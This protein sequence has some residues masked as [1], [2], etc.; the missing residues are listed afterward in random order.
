MSDFPRAEVE[1]TL[2]RCFE[3]RRR[4]DGSPYQVPGITVLLYAGEGRFSREE[5]LLNMVH[6]N[7]VIRESGWRPGPGFRP[8]PA[9]P[10]R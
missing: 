4:A 6:V 7:E 9:Q 1:A 8:P 3:T 10:R 5:D 2:Q